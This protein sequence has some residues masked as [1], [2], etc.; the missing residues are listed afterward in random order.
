MLDFVSPAS[1]LPLRTDDNCLVSEIGERF[2][3]VAGIPRFVSSDNY[4]AAFG[5]QW[6][7]HRTTQLD[8]CTHTSISQDRLTRCLGLPIADLRG[9]TVLEA[10]CGAGRFTELMVRAQAAVHAIDLSVAVEANRQNIGAAENYRVAQANI[11]DIPYPDNR[12]DFVVCLGVLQHLPSPEAGILALWKKLKPGGWLI[13]DHYARSLAVYT[14][15]SNLVVRPV[16]RRMKPERAMSVT[17]GLVRF[18]FP[19]HWLVRRSFLAQAALSRISPL[20]FYYRLYPNLAR[21]LHYEFSRLDTFDYLTDHYKHLR[22]A[23]EVRNFVTALGAVNVQ[24]WR[25][26]NGI[27]ARGQKPP[28]TLAQP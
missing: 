27:E 12:F 25:G 22:A 13:I 17:D 16:M 5:L 4:A 9:K 21:D 20:L 23:G 6:R 26:G 18:F 15:L 1:Q 24:V 28:L 2:P 10:G 19:L 3:I 7:L 14:K 8:S 11:Y